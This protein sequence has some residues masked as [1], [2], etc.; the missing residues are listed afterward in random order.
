MSGLFGDVDFGGIEEESNGFQ[1]MPEG[2]YVLVV[3][4]AE[5][6]DT[7]SKTGKY[8]NFKYKVVAPEKFNKRYIWDI[9][10]VKNDSEVAVKIGLERMKRLFSLAGFTEAEMKTKDHNDLVGKKFGAVIKHD[11]PKGY[12]AKEKITALTE[13]ELKEQSVPKNEVPDS[14][15]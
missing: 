15:L 11:K 10:N 8:I 3:D 13:A 1:L 6:K 14:W 5:L 4:S 12:E 9:V 7:R 2:N